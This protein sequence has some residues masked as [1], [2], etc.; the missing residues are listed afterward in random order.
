MA[1]SVGFGAI[2]GY[3]GELTLGLGTVVGVP[4]QLRPTRTRMG[5]GVRWNYG[6]WARKADGPGLSVCIEFHLG[7]ILEVVGVPGQL[8]PTRTRMGAGVRWNYGPWARKADGPGL[9]VCIEFHLGQILEV[10]GVP[11]QLRPTR[12]RMGAGVRWNYGPWARKADGPGLSVCIE[13]HLGQI[14]EVVGVPGQLRPTRTR[15]GA[16]VRWNYGPWARKADGPGLSVCIE[17]QTRGAAFSLGLF[18]CILWGHEDWGVGVSKQGNHWGNPLLGCQ[19]WVSFKIRCSKTDVF[20]KGEEPEELRLVGGRTRIWLDNVE[21]TGSE[22]ALWDCQH[23]SWGKHNCGHDEDVGVICA[24]HRDFRLL[25]GPDSC[26]GDLEIKHVNIWGSTCEL[27]EELR[28]ANVICRELHCGIAVPPPRNVTYTERKGKIWNEDI[29]CVGNEASQFQCPTVPRHGRNCTNP[30]YPV[31]NCLG[32]YS[33]FRIVNSS[34]TCSGRVELLY[35][36]QWGTLCSSHWDL[37]AANVLCRQLHCGIAM[38]LSDGG[39]FGM[40]NGSVWND[41][42][43]C[44]GTESHLS[45]CSFTALGNSKCP[46]WDTAGVICTGKEEALRLVDGDSHCA[47]RLEFLQDGNW[48]RVMAD[49]WDINKGHIV[50]RELHCGNAD[51]TFTFKAQTPGNDCVTWDSVMCDVN[52]TESTD[53]PTNQTSPAPACTDQ[54]LDVGVICSESKLLRLV[55]GPGR[56]AGRV[57]I[58]HQGEWGTVCDDLWDRADADVVCRQLGCGR[59]IN[60]TTMANH[61]RGTGKIW[62]DDLKCVGNETALWE[63]ESSPWG[64]HDCGHK[65]DAGV[66]C[67]EFPDLRLTGGSHA[68]EGRLEVYYNGTWG[69]VCNNGVYTG[70]ISVSVICSHLGCGSS[71]SS[72]D[73]FRY[74]I[75]NKPYWLDGIECRKNDRSLWQC[76]S[77]PWSQESCIVSEIA[78]IKCD[79]I[80]ENEPEVIHCPS[81]ENCTDMDRVRLMGGQDNCSGR[82]EIFFQGVWGTVCDDSWDMKDAEVVCRQLGCGTAQA[83]VGGAMFGQGS[84]PIWMD[85]VKCKGYERVLQDCQ[86]LRWNKSDCHHKEDAG[87]NCTYP[88]YLYVS[89]GLNEGDSLTAVDHKDVAPIGENEQTPYTPSIFPIVTCIV[90]GLLLSVGVIAIGILMKY[91]Y[92]YREAFSSLTDY[93]P[94]YEE[95]DYNLIINRHKSSGRSVYN[96]RDSAKKLEYYE[97][98][99]KLD[100]ELGKDNDRDGDLQYNY[101]DAEIAD[102]NDSTNVTISEETPIEKVPPYGYENVEESNQEETTVINNG[103]GSHSENQTEEYGYDEAVSGH[104]PRLL[105]KDETAINT[106]EDNNLVK[107]AKGFEALS[108]NNIFN[109]GPEIHDL[110]ISVTMDYDDTMVA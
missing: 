88:N 16:G 84:G 106:N 105:Y 60:A 49:Q 58:Y 31:V 53:C 18:V 75:G 42:I 41:K 77:N 23:N 104:F 62:L 5:A 100:R 73:R 47:G 7:Q 22:S 33:D 72:E 9:S 95:I 12:T 11:G 64:Q 4:G 109:H 32:S 15:M 107:S 19:G 97:S 78:Q 98:E 110:P 46:L 108:T 10:V 45:E 94:V 29:K 86:S 55:D 28:T 39:Y 71:G 91:L 67:S 20:G 76:P 8:R 38:S 35:A 101:D 66:I 25:G 24:D 81:S 61:G 99:E 44:K 37:Q 103:D 27:D 57:E 52:K 30:Y 48:N 3:A 96:S 74:G 2:W 43:H 59:A 70:S 21:C 26:S 14:L 6:P 54:N 90:L 51:S 34:D 17:F 13:F 69:S 85:E 50:C 87:V 65:E 89:D 40:S 36:E 80:P 102:P 82:V 1:S 56:C 68:C 92:R 93:N 79:R 83:A 63:C